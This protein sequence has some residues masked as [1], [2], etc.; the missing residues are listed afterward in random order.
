MW[1]KVQVINRQ[2]QSEDRSMA[3]LQ[4]TTEICMKNKGGNITGNEDGWFKQ[5]ERSTTQD[6]GYR[7][8]GHELSPLW[9]M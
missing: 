6:G 8:D 7:M 2:D 5:G 3:I 4:F 1:V 9:N